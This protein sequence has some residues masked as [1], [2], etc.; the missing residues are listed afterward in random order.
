MENDHK[1]QLSVAAAAAVVVVFLCVCVYRKKSNIKAMRP[2]ALTG[3]KEMNAHFKRLLTN[4]RMNC[5]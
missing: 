2:S 4:L 5:D 3:E 1:I